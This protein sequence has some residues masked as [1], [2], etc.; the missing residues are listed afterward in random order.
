MS[1]DEK[2][3]IDEL[4]SRG[5]SAKQAKEALDE[6]GGHVDDAIDFLYSKGRAV[7]RASMR[8]RSVV[9]VQSD[10]TVADPIHSKPSHETED[11]PSATPSIALLAYRQANS[12]KR[13][14]QTTTSRRSLESSSSPFTPSPPLK[15]KGDKVAA[16]VPMGAGANEIMAKNKASLFRADEDLRAKKMAAS[17]GALEKDSESTVAPST[18]GGATIQTASAMMAN[19]RQPSYTRSDNAPGAFPVGTSENALSYPDELESGTAQQSLRQ[20]E[21]ELVDHDR[22][23]QILESRLLLELERQR[24]TVAVAEAI[25]E[26]ELKRQRRKRFA[27]IIGIVVV[28]VAIAVGVAVGVGGSPSPQETVAP[29]A[30]PTFSPVPEEIVALIAPLSF[31]DGASLNDPSSPQS[32]AARWLAGNEFLDTYSDAR[33]IQRYAMATFYYSTNG[34]KWKETQ[35]WLSDGNECTE[36]WYAEFDSDNDRLKCDANNMVTDIL[37]EENNLAGTLPDE[38]A[39]LSSTFF[40]IEMGENNIQGTLPSVLGLMTNLK[41]FDIGKNNVTSTIPTE[42]GLLTTLESLLLDSNGFFG[43]IP[44]E[45]ALMTSLKTLE[46]DDNSL[47]GTIPGI[48]IL[49]ALQN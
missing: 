24:G 19:V 21:A 48:T 47:S 14:P 32:A 8:K 41:R 2:S 30:A 9:T 39:F 4:V 29:T 15:T 42:V 13:T 36:W 22:E 40:E 16:G 25:P 5:Y 46:I 20:V 45:M 11:R 27:L 18:A 1:L 44:S 35:G 26:R 43:T 49:G 31:D 6:N 17:D 7:K 34:D 28:I 12:A 10:V 38:I 33:K 37:I 23:N 3:S